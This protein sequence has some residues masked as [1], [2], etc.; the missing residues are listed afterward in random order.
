M[1]SPFCLLTVSVHPGRCGVWK[2]VSWVTSLVS[3]YCFNNRIHNRIT[4]PEI[5]GIVAVS[6]EGG[7]WVLHI[8]A[9]ESLTFRV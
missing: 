2:T 9:D 8:H 7:S 3:S 4:C 5:P 1:A 6:A